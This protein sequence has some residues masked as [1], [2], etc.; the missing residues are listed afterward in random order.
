MFQNRAARL[1][2]CMQGSSLSVDVVLWINM[3]S[4][5]NRHDAPYQVRANTQPDSGE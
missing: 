2:L 5:S 1:F 3:E 4:Q